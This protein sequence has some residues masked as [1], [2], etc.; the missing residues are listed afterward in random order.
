MSGIRISRFEDLQCWQ[1]ARTL[2]KMVYEAINSN[3]VSG[4]DL[5]FVCQFM[6]AAVSSMSNITE[7][8]SQETD[9]VFLGGLWIS[10]GSIAGVQSLSCA[11]MHLGY[12]KGDEMNA[13]YHQAE[14]VASLLSGFI[15]YFRKSSGRR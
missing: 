15:K 7:G 1:E 11:A 14:I 5:Q 10:K 12:S 4:A 3:K 8:F 2:V 13:I 6:S 9:K